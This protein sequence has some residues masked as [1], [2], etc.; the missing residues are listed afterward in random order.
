MKTKQQLI[1]ENLL[2]INQ[3]AKRS[4]VHRDQIIAIADSMGVD[5][6]RRDADIRKVRRHEAMSRALGGRV[7]AL[8]ADLFAMRLDNSKIIEKYDITRNT[9]QYWLD[10][11]NVDRAKRI[12]HL[13]DIKPQRQRRVEFNSVVHEAMNGARSLELLTLDWRAI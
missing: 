5:Q 11:H 10:Y 4:G 1:S 12:R 7:D 3:I 13:L 8:A 9:L 6:A 2:T